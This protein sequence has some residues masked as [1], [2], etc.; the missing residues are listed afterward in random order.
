M[1][2]EGICDVILK[3]RAGMQSD[4]AL[5]VGIS[6]IDASGKGYVAT[7]IAAALEAD[8][9]R[10]ALINVDGWLNLPTV[11]FAGH[12]QGEHFYRHALRLDEMF[13]QLIEPLKDTRAAD[14]MMDFAEETANEFRRH[15]YS[16]RD[17]DI[18]LL[19]GIFIYKRKF[20]DHFDL[21]IWIDC[22]FEK[23]LARAIDRGQENL[24]PEATVRAYE[25]IYFPAQRLHLKL[26]DPISGAEII[27]RN[28]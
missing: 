22:G 28:D 10:V 9:Y 3:R 20:V 5:L 15:Q 14:L 21:K 18:I 25:Q 26:D 23:A 11:R 6:G 27:F 24:S 19:E 16:L 2:V 8:R 17:I 12:N 7:Q 13:E 1:N 4:R